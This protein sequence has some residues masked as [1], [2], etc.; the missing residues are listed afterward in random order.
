M[1]QQIVGSWNKNLGC[2]DV[3]WIDCWDRLLRIFSQIVVGTGLVDRFG[4]RGLGLFYLKKEKENWCCKMWALGLL[5]NGSNK[6]LSDCVQGVCCFDW[7][8]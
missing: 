7:V 8:V 4:F 2:C 6:G 3:L 1:F 5:T